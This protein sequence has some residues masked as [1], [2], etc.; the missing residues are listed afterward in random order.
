MYYLNSLQVR[1]QIEEKAT[2]TTRKRISR[3]ALA[4]LSLEVPPLP[5]QKKI[6]EILSG[7]DKCIDKIVSKAQK[8]RNILQ[9][10]FVELDEVENQ[11]QTELLGE[12]VTIQN[13]Y[14]FQSRMFTEEKDGIPLIRISDIQNGVVDLS[15]SKK[16]PANFSVSDDYIIHKGDIL[17]AM[18]GATTGKVGISCSETICLLNQRVGKFSFQRSD[19][20]NKFVSQLLLS[21]Y[22][23]NRLLAAAA[24]GAQPNIS[25][26]GI[27]ALEIPLPDESRQSNLS[28]A[29]SGIRNQI[30]SQNKLATKY[31]YLKNSLSSGLLS[32]RKRISV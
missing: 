24:G 12:F 31:L 3:S 21:G 23:E 14:A 5:E 15:K 6:A 27:E 29:I 17:I 2:G 19:V 16:I 9:G 11:G 18:S 32:G 22:L 1:S 8:M 10:I 25:G 30:R 7:I 4:N 20:T 28:R 26:S 13:G